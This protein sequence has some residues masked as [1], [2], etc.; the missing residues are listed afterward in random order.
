MRGASSPP[1]FVCKWSNVLKLEVVRSPGR[2]FAAN[3]LKALLAHVVL[4][5]DVAF[6]AE[7]T[8]C[9]MNIYLKGNIILANV[10]LRFRKREAL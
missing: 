10:P 7:D 8:T 4:N 1:L 3:E 2:F 6:A 5:Y 9:S